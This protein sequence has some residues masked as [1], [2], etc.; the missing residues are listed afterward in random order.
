MMR[1][2]VK[3]TDA[4]KDERLWRDGHF[5][6]H[7]FAELEIDTATYQR[8]LELPE[9]VLEPLENAHVSHDSGVDEGGARPRASRGR[10]NS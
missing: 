4:V 6:T 5:I 3:T 1:V 7:E 2:R 10:H 9:L 8:W